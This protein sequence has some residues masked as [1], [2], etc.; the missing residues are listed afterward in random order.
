MVMRRDG[1]LHIG[2]VLKGTRTRLGVDI[3]T[4][5]RDTKIRAKYLRALENE[6]WDTLP[7]PTYVKAFLRTYASYLGLDA[8]AL[9]D[10]YRRTIERSP[11][12]EQPTCSRSRFSSG[13]AVRLIRVARGRGASDFSSSQS[14]GRSRP[15]CW[16]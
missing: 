6:E 5:E 2:E 12:S 10:E 8:E 7:G 15:P 4:L 9:V 1:E 16:S 3:A 13:A 14:W 11:D